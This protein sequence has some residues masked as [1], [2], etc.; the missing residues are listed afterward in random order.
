MCMDTCVGFVIDMCIG[1]GPGYLVPLYSVYARAPCSGNDLGLMNGMTEANAVQRIMSMEGGIQGHCAGCLI[2]T[3][4]AGIKR[5]VSRSVL[6]H[7]MPCRATPRRTPAP[8]CAVCLHACMHCMPACLHA[9]YGMLGMKGL[10]LR[11]SRDGGNVATQP[12]QQ[13]VKCVRACES[14]RVHGWRGGCMRT[15]TPKR[16]P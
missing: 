15:F 7:A 1:P 9:L 10:R 11:A 12:R 14:T 4:Q 3:A 2:A 8:R 6:S 16:L 13:S 5:S